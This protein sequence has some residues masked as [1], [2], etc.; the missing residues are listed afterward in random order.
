MSITRTTAFLAAIGLLVP[1]GAAQNGPPP[2]SVRV[3]EVR[4]QTVERMREV[5]GE[6]RA[7]RRAE[8]AS[9]EE[10]LGIELGVDI[11]DEIEAGRVIARLEDERR[12][13]DVARLEAEVA[14][15]DAV[16]AE[17]TAQVGKTK[18]DL[19]RLVELRSRQG[20]SQ[21]EVD[22]AKT[23]LAEAEARRAQARA[24]LESRRVA[25]STARTRLEDMVITAPFSGSVVS[26]MTEV[27]QWISQGDTVVEMLSYDTVDVFL[28][29]P[30]RF[31]EALR[32][33][34]GQVRLRLD[35]IEDEITAPVAT[36][37]AQGDRLART[38]PVRVRLENPDHAIRPGM[39]VQG[40][41]PTGEPMEALT[42]HKDAVMRSEV[43]V[44]VYFNNDGAAATAPIEPLFALGERVAVR[45][46]TL[47]P[48]MELVIEGNERLFVSQ[49][50]II[51]RD[52][53]PSARVGGD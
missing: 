3:D 11:G 18:R 44:F 17:R 46:P 23:A 31:L 38:F 30:E 32:R 48:G 39:S 50:L 7:V 27:G 49:P 8:V 41:V 16:V 1:L 5:T 36:I 6:V 14:S 52:G 10:G 9:Q 13:L 22:D 24:D 29:V 51:Q 47:A 33:S 4:Q 15:H 37:V 19:E 25:L 26:K 43:G 42:V 34:D 53:A 40:M 28:D 35:A 2:A 20:A 12:R 45:S 21:N